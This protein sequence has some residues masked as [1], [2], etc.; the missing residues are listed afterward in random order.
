MVWSMHVLKVLGVVIVR[1]DRSAFAFPLGGRVTHAAGARSRPRVALL[2]ARL[3][4]ALETGVSL[5][6]DLGV[7]TSS[8]V[9]Y[10]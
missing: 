7:G 5:R 9:F 1:R 3:S 8:P 4:G 10:G 2:L 6:R